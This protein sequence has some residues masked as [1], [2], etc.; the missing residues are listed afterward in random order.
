[1][2]AASINPQVFLWSD[3]GTDGGTGA[4]QFLSGLCFLEPHAHFFFPT[5]GPADSKLRSTT[6]CLAVDLQRR[7]VYRGNSI[8]Q[9]SFTANLSQS[10]SPECA[11]L[12]RSAGDSR[13]SNSSHGS[14]RAPPD[15]MNSDPWSRNTPTLFGWLNHDNYRYTKKK[16]NV[17]KEESFKKWNLE[18]V[19]SSD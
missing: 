18:F 3:A 13:F 7:E 11:W 12:L 1:M 19:L 16:I 10:Y 14:S 15:G 2:E 5:V 8:L 4:W 9:T 17:S 6:R